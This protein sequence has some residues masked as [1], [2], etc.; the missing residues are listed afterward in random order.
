[1]TQLNPQNG[2]NQFRL[3]ISFSGIVDE[4]VRFTEF[5]RAEVEHRVWMQ[6][7]E[8][9]FN[10][11]EDVRR[12]GVTP[13]EFDDRMQQLYREGN[14]FIFETMVFSANATR[15][16]WTEEAI[17]RIRLHAERTGR[18][19]DQLRILI[20]GDGAGTDSLHLA[21]HGFRVDY[22][23]VPGSRTYGF[24]TK[25]F[26]FYKFLDDYIFLVTDYAS[27]LAENYDVIVCFDV[28]EHLPNPAGSVR[29]IRMML[30]VGG[31]AL[32]T[33]DFGDIVAWL[34]THLNVSSRFA[35]TT[36]FLFMR[37]RMVLSWYSRESLFK[38]MEFVRVD[39][40]TA[41]QRWQLWRDPRVRG[42]Y[43]GR[44]VRRIT[45]RL[46]KLPYLGG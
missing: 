28:L 44:H 18:T 31:I 2:Q 43:L 36:P 3:P 39:R 45:R 11:R 25:R 9:G 12:F 40:V 37:N 41:A 1:V 24:A 14:G 20:L 29:D 32:I 10:V 15:R 30:R 46:D 38:P 35:G 19:P 42:A 21:A 27:C 16:R 8:P 26:Q 22:F 5:E 6:L 7:L 4:I 17:A 23:D 34:P 13:H 33:E